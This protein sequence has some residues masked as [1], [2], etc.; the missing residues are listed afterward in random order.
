[1]L[2]AHQAWSPHL[3]GEQDYG[4]LAWQ[5]VSMHCSILPCDYVCVEVYQTFVCIAKTTKGGEHMHKPFRKVF[6]DLQ[7][8]VV[9]Q[10]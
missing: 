2:A 7:L 3:A 9:V 1:M 10:E 8:A 6:I 4:H 5:L